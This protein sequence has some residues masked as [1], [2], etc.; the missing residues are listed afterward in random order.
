MSAPQSLFFPSAYAST[1]R[2]TQPIFGNKVLHVKYLPTH[3][4]RRHHI[5]RT[6]HTFNC[7]QTELVFLYC[8]V[9]LMIKGK[10]KNPSLSFVTLVL[11]LAQFEKAD[12]FLSIH[13]SPLRSS[14]L[15]IALWILQIELKSI[16]S[17]KQSSMSLQYFRGTAH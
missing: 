12:R 4:Q 2:T 9:S 3:D 16:L 11:H 10:P 7:T 6:L 13:S 5:R 14:H 8:K 1:K 15:Q 17:E